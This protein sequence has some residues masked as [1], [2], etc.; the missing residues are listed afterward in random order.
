[1]RLYGIAVT[2]INCRLLIS[3]LV[4]EGSPESFEIAERISG[5]VRVHDATRQLPARHR[6]AQVA[7][8]G[9][10]RSLV[11]NVARYQRKLPS[12]PHWRSNR[13]ELAIFDHLQKRNILRV[14][15]EQSP[16]EGP[17]L[18]G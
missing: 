16:Y 9:A 8:E 11:V 12:E 13:P 3:S 6:P 15:A 18:A 5:G 2:D 10:H 17:L 7:L 14:S 4:A 1:M